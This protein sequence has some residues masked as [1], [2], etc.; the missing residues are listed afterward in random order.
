[1]DQE[2]RDLAPYQLT[3]AA[4]QGNVEGVGGSRVALSTGLDVGLPSNS[5][6]SRDLAGCTCSI[7]ISVSRLF[8]FIN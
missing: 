1:M 4:G 2:Q 5:Q 3:N 6:S 7:K 8:E